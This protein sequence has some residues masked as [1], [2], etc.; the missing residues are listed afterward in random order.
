MREE[1]LEMRN[2]IRDGKG[3]RRNERGEIILNSQFSN[4]KSSKGFTFIEL[5]LYMAIMTF[6]ISSLVPFAWNIIGTGAKSAT[7]QEVFSSARY[8]SER[9]KYEIRDASGIN[10]V[11]ATSI[12]LSN[13]NAAKNPTI[14]DLSGGKIRVKYGAS[15]AVNINS[16][17][18]TVS[19]LAF[20]NYTSGDNK[21]KNIQFT[22]TLQSNY[23]TTRQ[24]YIETTSIRGDAEVRSN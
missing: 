11:A 21:T 24:E 8:V 18:T 22:F 12:S 20:T 2:K 5:I 4:L 23:S 14:I 7:Q 13:S 1:K 15:S 10:S 6:I 9:I 3:E 16:T 19:S 17:D